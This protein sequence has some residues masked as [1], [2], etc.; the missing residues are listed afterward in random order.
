MGNYGNGRKG[1]KREGRREGG[2]VRGGKGHL[3]AC[4]T[5]SQ[6]VGVQEKEGGDQLVD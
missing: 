5:Q 4:Q 2:R 6:D 3:L 1:Y